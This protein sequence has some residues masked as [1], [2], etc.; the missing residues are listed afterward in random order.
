MDV[1]TGE[2]QAQ[3]P[4]RIGR[5]TA[6]SSYDIY[7]VDTPK[8]KEADG[9]NGMP[10]DEPPKRRRQK[11]RPRSGKRKN[12]NIVTDNDDNLN[13]AEDPADPALEQGMRE[14]DEHSPEML[15][16]HNDAED[17]NYQ[18]VSE[19]EISLGDNEFIVRRTL[20]TRAPPSE[21]Y[22]HRKEPE[23]AEATA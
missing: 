12:N 13:Q 14:D 10:V 7:M 21:A 9:D 1:D 8:E 20:R 16:D 19:E 2:E 23:E 18:P 11:H 17:S 5:W 3:N 22:R 15:S 6:T 4:P